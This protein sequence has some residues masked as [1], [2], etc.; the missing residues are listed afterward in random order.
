MT[1]DYVP[2]LVAH[3]P[4]PVK[5]SSEV[6]DALIVYR[7]VLA[8]AADRSVVIAAIGFATNLA[9]LLRSPPDEISPLGGREL[10]AQKVKRIV[11]QGG[12][13]PKRHLPIR[14]NAAENEF[15]WGCGK[16]WYDSTPCDGEAA[17]AVMR[18]PPTVEQIFS[19]VGGE[20]G[21][22]GRDVL[23]CAPETNPCRQA[24]QRTL[25]AWNQDPQGG[26]AS[27]DPVVTLVAVRGVQAIPGAFTVRGANLLAHN[28]TNYWVDEGVDPTAAAPRDWPKADR[29]TAPPAN[30]SY[31]AMEGDG[32]WKAMETRARQRGGP[33][34]V[35]E[36]LKQ[37]IDRLLCR[38]PG[39][40][41]RA[42]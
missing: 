9:P 29:Y 17:F 22:G 39:A 21:T 1:G 27:W 5:R 38:S 8:A 3:W 34:R 41:H 19:E 42:R 10:V 14:G 35:V 11:W 16:R 7:R 15:N 36:D 6:E 37:E 40:H 20:I 24:F 2:Y 25:T 18:M 23:A 31:L 26:R 28:G 33:P 12:W 30:Q 32:P 4:A 13:Y